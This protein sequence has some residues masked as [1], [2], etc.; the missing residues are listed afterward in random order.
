[1]KWLND[2]SFNANIYMGWRE[3]R[4]LQGGHHLAFLLAVKK[5]VM[6][7]HADEGSEV[8]ADRIV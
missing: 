3:K 5:A 8:V 7:L 4:H 2:S 1:M 6:V